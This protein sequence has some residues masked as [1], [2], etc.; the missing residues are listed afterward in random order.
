[1]QHGVH[2]SNPF[3]HVVNDDFIDNYI[4]LSDHNQQNLSPIIQL[5]CDHYSEEETVTLDD[6][7]LLSKEQECHLF[8]NKGECMH[9]HSS[10]L[11]QHDCDLGFEDTVVYLLESYLSYSLKISYFI[12]SLELVGEYDSLKKFLSLLLYFCYYLLIS[13][14][15]VIMSIVKLLEWLLWKFSFT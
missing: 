4:F 13:A 11:N 5:S 10:F 7:E 14:I 12:I 3:E 15:D 1:L 2:F 6:Q 9:C 8:S